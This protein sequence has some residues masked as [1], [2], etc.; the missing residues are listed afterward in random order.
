MTLLFGINHHPVVCIH[1]RG[2]KAVGSR[3][4]MRTDCHL[5]QAAACLEKT[6]HS[7][8]ALALSCSSE[9]INGG[10]IRR[11][12]R[13]RSGSRS[14][15]PSNSARL[16]AS[17]SFSLSF[18]LFFFFFCFL[19]FLLSFG[20]RVRRVEGWGRFFSR[21]ASSF[22]GFVSYD[23]RGMNKFRSFRV[24]FVIYWR[25]LHAGTSKYTFAWRLIIFKSKSSLFVK[26]NEIIVVFFCHPVWGVER[27]VLWFLI[28]KERIHFLP[29]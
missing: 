1:G 22:S 4:W 10:L 28:F 13:R 11:C 2:I 27:R 14:P 23:S 16:R 19:S 20:S 18:L 3:T 9:D 29:T 6:L 17:F 25:G 21:M 24:N 15:F 7:R 26:F 5:L 12:L 8:P